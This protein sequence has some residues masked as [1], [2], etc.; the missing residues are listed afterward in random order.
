MLLKGL[1][2]YWK[3]VFINNLAVIQNLKNLKLNAIYKSLSL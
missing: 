1:A 2:L 3:L